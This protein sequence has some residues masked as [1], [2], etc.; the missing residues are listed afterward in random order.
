MAI[1]AYDEDYLANAQAILGHAVD[2]AVMSLN[3]EPDAFGNSFAVSPVSKQFAAGNP[4]YIAGMNGCEL[5]REVLYETHTPFTDTDDIMYLDKS[6]EYWSG[7]AL[8]FYQWYSTRSFTEILS[9]VRL[10]N[11]IEMYHLYH[12][13]DVTHFSEHMDELMHEAYPYTRLKTKRM[14]SGL[15]QSELA[16]ESGVA[17]RQIQLFEQRQRNINSA[18]AI[19]LL[20]LSKALHCCI[21]DLMEVE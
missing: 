1:R 6:P 14:N 2:F 16:A 13:M 3:L 17:L 5:A 15:S 9:V 10:S 18:A 7:W 11:I 20:R 8:A 4:K 12:E 19:T 21:E